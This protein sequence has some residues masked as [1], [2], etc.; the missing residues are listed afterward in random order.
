MEKV[1]K[2]SNSDK[3]LMQKPGKNG[4]TNRFLVTVNVLGSAGPIRFVANEGDS[5][6]EVID[7]ALKL[8][9]REQRLPQLG[10]DVNSFLL[11][12]ANAGL[13]ALKPSE[14][15]KSSGMR[16]FILC[17]KEGIPQMKESKSEII[18]RKRG[19]SLKAWLNKS[20]TF[21]ISSH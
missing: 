1:L 14:S 20:L 5:V 8:Y 19:N 21:K 3:G 6:S 16:N 10:S 7:A 13:D 15:V 2:K 18:A 17:K 12:P 4:N 11:Y 9:G